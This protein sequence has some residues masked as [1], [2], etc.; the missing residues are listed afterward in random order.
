MLR[1][2]IVF[3]GTNL[4]SS[5]GEDGILTAKE[6]TNLNLQGT[7]LVVLSACDTGL[8]EEPSVGEGVYGLR[9]A[10]A[11]AGTQS[12]MMSLWKANDRVTLELMVNYYQ[13]L[14]EGVGRGPNL[15]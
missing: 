11:L 5:G 13:K 6:A 9:R 10:L 3:A 2:G 8:G 12:Q 15:L 7:Q 14:K 1:S 4:R